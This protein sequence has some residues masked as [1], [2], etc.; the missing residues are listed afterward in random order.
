MPKLIEVPGQG[1]VEFPDSMD[2][3]QI[4]QAIKRTLSTSAAPSPAPEKP[5]VM[6]T[7]GIAAGRGTDKLLS[8]LTQLY[9]RAIGDEAVLRGLSIREA[10]MD[11]AYKPLQQQRPVLTAIGEAAPM[12]AVPAS[13]MSTVTRAAAAGALPGLLSYGSDKERLAAGSIGA[14]AGGV[15]NLAARGVSKLLQPTAQTA[16]IS[17]DAVNAAKR[18]GVNLSAGERTQNPALVSFENYLLRSP[19]SSGPMQAKQ[20]ANQTAMSRAAAGAMGQNADDLSEGVF[21][22][23]KRG[24]GD[25]FERLQGITRPKLDDNFLTALAGIDSENLAKGAFKSPKVDRLVTKGLDLAAKGE[26]SGTAYKQIRTELTNEAS[27]AFKNGDATTGQAYKAL[28]KALDDAAE[29]SLSEVDQKAWQQTRAQWQAYKTLTKGQVAEGGNLSPARLAAA[30]RQQGDGLRT[31]SASGPLADIARIGES[32]K[33]AQNPASGQLMQ[34]MLYGNPLTG[35]PM[36]AGNRA[37]Q[38]A[39]SR[40]MMQR[41]LANGLLDIGPGGEAAL[42]RL[43]MPGA[44]ASLGGLLG[45]Q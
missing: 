37:L 17:D 5:G 38:A 39:Y 6:Q 29:K 28:R 1:V 8:G 43:A 20:L 9:G 7:L 32:V 11:E 19:G 23:A 36:M 34:Q 45:A 18:L 10:G 22:A 25:E 24:I 44:S 33:G 41:Y 42:T 30:V 4:A 27:K 21:A 3:A 16:S 13:A 31:G 14:A 12:M 40:P 26:L 35:L 2:D 15:S